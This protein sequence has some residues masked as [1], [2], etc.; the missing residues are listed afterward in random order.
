MDLWFQ[1]SAVI[2]LLGLFEDT[3]LL[4]PDKFS[5]KVLQ[6]L[7]SWWQDYVWSL[8]L[9]DIA[10][11]KVIRCKPLL[12][13][14][15]RFP[16][17]YVRRMYD[18]LF[19]EICSESGY[20]NGDWLCHLNGNSGVG[21]LA[22]LWYFIIRGAIELRDTDI[23]EELL[24]LY[25][26]AG[27]IWEFKGNTL[28]VAKRDN[29]TLDTWCSVLVAASPAAE[30]VKAAKADWKKTVMYMYPWEEDEYAGLVEL[31]KIHYQN[32]KAEIE[33][34][35]ASLRSLERW[36]NVKYKFGD[37]MVQ[38]SSG[39]AD[40]VQLPI[41]K[42]SVQQML[43]EDVKEQGRPARQSRTASSCHPV[44]AEA[45]QTHISALRAWNDIYAGT[46]T[47]DAG[48]DLRR[49]EGLSSNKNAY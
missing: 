5:P 11:G 12:G 39:S 36:A 18:S 41:L 2:V 22:F 1:S 49:D 45:L 40:L 47:N 48:E 4:C 34:L 6:S 32:L 15:K 38:I 44:A 23:D 28:H 10:A 9:E 29:V 19:A 37:T 14:H 20:A 35:R 27:F 16:G 21:K 43:R 46:R 30:N 17:L 8:K 3:N 33:T 26:S 13:A 31:W 42:E 24:I 25:E 7:Q